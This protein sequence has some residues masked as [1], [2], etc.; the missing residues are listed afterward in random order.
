MQGSDDIW[1]SQEGRVLFSQH[2]NQHVKNER[3]FFA[4]HT[5]SVVQ[6]LVQ[7]QVVEKMKKLVQF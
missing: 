2:T 7:G 6:Q 3:V 5:T 1:Q 4:R